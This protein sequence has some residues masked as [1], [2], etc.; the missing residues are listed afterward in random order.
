M[1]ELKKQ[2]AELSALYESYI[3]DAIETNDPTRIEKIKELNVKIAAVLDEMIRL[4]TEMR[5]ESD[6]VNVYRDELINKLRKIQMDYNGLLEN[7]DK[8]NTLRR[9]RETEEGRANKGLYLYLILF[10]GACI[11][12]LLVILFRGQK[13]ESATISPTVPAMAAPFI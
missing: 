12:V 10:I 7:T 8:L 1:D 5:K 4:T 3:K 9:I 11:F 13:S 2:Y 6:N